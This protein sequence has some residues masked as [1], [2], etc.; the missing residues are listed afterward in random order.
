MACIQDCS[1]GVLHLSA[2]LLIAFDLA[3]EGDFDGLFGLVVEVCTG[4][5]VPLLRLEEWIST[6]GSRGMGGHVSNLDVSWEE[7]PVPAN[8]TC[9]I[10]GQQTPLWLSK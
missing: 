9:F 5:D 6:W 3:L 7:S 8:I 4:R 1:S 2:G 10:T